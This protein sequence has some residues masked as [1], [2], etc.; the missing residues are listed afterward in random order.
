MYLHDVGLYGDILSSH[1]S[2]GM[3]DQWHSS[4]FYGAVSGNHTLSLNVIDN[5]ASYTV[6]FYLEATA[7][8]EVLMLDL[9]CQLI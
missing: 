3:G 4:A 7:A 8:Q 1:G 9:F 2:N 6:P 5:V